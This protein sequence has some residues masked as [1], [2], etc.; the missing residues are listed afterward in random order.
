MLVILNECAARSEESPCLVQSWASGF[1]LYDPFK[2]SFLS[3]ST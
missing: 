3:S 2:R 1:I